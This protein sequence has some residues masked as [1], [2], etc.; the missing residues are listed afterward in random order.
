MSHSATC[1]MCLKCPIQKINLRPILTTA[2]FQSI[3][4][5]KTDKDLL[6]LWNDVLVVAAAAEP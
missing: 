5:I 4:K 2:E 1:L 6:Y 3:Q